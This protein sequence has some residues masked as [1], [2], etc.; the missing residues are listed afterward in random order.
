MHDP[1]TA[2]ARPSPFDPYLVLFLR[3]IDGLPDGFA[4]TSHAATICAA[5]DWP[6]AFAEAL[7]VSARARGLLE[8]YAARGPRGRSRWQVSPRGRG[9]L[10]PA[11]PPPVEGT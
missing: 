8:P 7:F 5:L 3:G 6:P 1:T 10:D 4:P 11:P 2:P 9:W